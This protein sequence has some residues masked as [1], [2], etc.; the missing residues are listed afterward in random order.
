MKALIV[1]DEKH[2]RAAIRMLVKWEA[3]GIDTILEAP[4]G[5]AATEIIAR[6]APQI[7]MTDMMMPVKNGAQLLEWI[8][9]QAP[10][11]K[12]IVI[13]GHDDFSLLRHTVQYGG[14]DYILK[15]ID[16]EQLNAALDK[17]VE[18]WRS[19]EAVRNH[20]LERNIQINQIKP[21]YWDK[22]LSNLLADPAQ[23][24]STAGT[25][26]KELGLSA[27]T[28]TI[29][30][31]I[32]SLDTMERSLKDKF[33]SNQELLLFSLINI[34]NEFL[35]VQHRG[36]AFRHW[37]SD[38]EIVLLLWLAPDKA[39]G[40]LSEINEG[41]RQTL[42]CKLDFG[43]GEPHSFPLGLSASYKEAQESLN[44]RNLLVKTSWIH[45]I[46]TSSFV[47]PKR[48]LR[49]SDFEER[50]LVAIRSGSHEQIQMSVQLWIDAVKEVD[51]I[52]PRQL[53]HWWNEFNM[54]KRRW[55]QDFFPDQGEDNSELKAISEPSGFIIPLDEQ[56]ILSLKLWQ[57]ELTR[58]MQQLSK[59]MLEHQQKGSNII[60]EIAKYI[61]NNYSQ[62]IT[63]QDMGHRFYLSREYISRKFKQQFHVN[64]SDYLGKIRIDKAKL[65]LLNPHLRISQIAEMVGYQDEKYFSKVF[66]KTEGVS[67]NEYRKLL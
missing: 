44:Q 20:S 56:G 50:L 24:E 9:S 47:P 45:S 57:Q 21:V 1:D 29:R 54:L 53:N 42:R 66:K 64:L 26:H 11:S 27:E 43:L 41:M 62:D 32:L 51:T 46:G 14:T 58:S 12:T 5:Q 13:S 34:C 10:H 3:H 61:E 35:H 6:E 16:A 55:V 18:T 65:L 15:P 49:F 40:V 7:I 38:H 39:A 59:L 19:E 25:L 22:L 23:Y 63:L 36:F 48:L 31:A 60:F 67:P 17:A 33:Y 2:V 52:T 8:H 37:N 4:D 30:V 28:T